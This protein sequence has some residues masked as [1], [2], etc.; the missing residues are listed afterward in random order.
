MPSR[1]AGKNV[2]RLN[3]MGYKH[4]DPRAYTAFDPKM[5]TIGGLGGGAP[6]PTGMHGQTGGLYQDA[7]GNWHR[8]AAGMMVGAQQ[9]GYQAGNRQT[10]NTLFRHPDYAGG[11]WRPVNGMELRGGVPEGSEFKEG[12]PH[13]YNRAG[14][15]HVPGV[16]G[17]GRLRHQS[18]DIS[19]GTYGKGNK[20]PQAPSGTA[21]SWEW[22]AYENEMQA[23]KNKVFYGQIL[24]DMAHANKGFDDAENAFRSVANLGIYGPEGMNTIVQAGT[25]KVRDNLNEMLPTLITQ[26]N[27]GEALGRANAMKGLVGN[28]P[29]GLA[30]QTGQL[31]KVM[32]DQILGPSLQNQANRNLGLKKNVQEQINATHMVDADLIKENMSSKY[33]AVQDLAQVAAMRQGNIGAFASILNTSSDNAKMQ[34]NE[35]MQK[36]QNNFNLTRDKMQAYYHQVSQYYDYLMQKDW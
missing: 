19:T 11:A 28:M 4:L 5:G 30:G 3:Q 26:A 35:K 16:G 18:Y 34:F 14:G 27:Q 1:R 12:K 10:S 21:P 17:D 13:I 23:W 8:R 2:K 36:I 20:M 25:Q 29:G 15:A 31:S 24:N 32:A 7:F 22:E 9:T 33:Q 6:Y